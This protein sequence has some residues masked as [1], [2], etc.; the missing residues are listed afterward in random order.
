[1]RE[2]ERL[3]K[4]AAARF[5]ALACN[6]HGGS[7]AFGR[8]TTLTLRVVDLRG[9]VP[10]VKGLHRTFPPPSAVDVRPHERRV[11]FLDYPETGDV[12]LYDSGRVNTNDAP[13]VAN[14]RHRAT[15]GPLRKWRRWSA[16]DAAY[17]FGYSF[18]EYTTLPFRLVDH[19]PM[20]A[21]RTPRG[22]ELWYRFPR[23]TDT[24]SEIQGF[25]FDDSGLLLRHD[26]RAEIMGSV[27]NGAHVHRAHE[28]VQG[29]LF[30]T[31]RTVY[32]KPWHYP[33]R[34]MLP[35]PVLSARVVPRQ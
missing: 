35:V 15:F 19:E 10:W 24:H 3:S 13:S 7:Q 12:T 14:A 6:R 11:R 33:I 30:A 23:G 31:H 17:F 16:L 29:V 18:I 2:I 25:F 20:D 26:Y 32:A 5:V 22:V 8:I 21:R 34:A 1:V 28:M 27:F 9:T 4:G